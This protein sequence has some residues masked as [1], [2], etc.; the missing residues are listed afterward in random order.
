[1]DT[2]QRLHRAMNQGRAPHSPET[3][4]ITLMLHDL[5]AEYAAEGWTLGYE[6]A[7]DSPRFASDGT[8]V[9]NLTLFAEDQR[10]NW[11]QVLAR[12]SLTDDDAADD[13]ARV[14]ESG[15]HVLIQ[16]VHQETG[17]QVIHWID[18]SELHALVA[19]DGKGTTKRRADLSRAVSR[20][21]A[22][23]AIDAVRAL[24]APARDTA[25]ARVARKQ[26][27]LKS[28]GKGRRER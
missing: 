14:P 4:E 11:G 12:R 8:E 13:L 2:R 25:A 15:H 5:A 7:D 10:R 1:M 27:R 21:D 3:Q 20:G 9:D 28:A 22:L 26:D 19:G 24:V 23:P 18:R 16:L 6:I 17:A